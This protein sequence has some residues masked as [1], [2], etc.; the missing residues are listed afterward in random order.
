[1]DDIVA[2]QMHLCQLYDDFHV[3]DLTLRRRTLLEFSSPQAQAGAAGAGT[4]TGV[5]TAVAVGWEKW[6]PNK[7]HILEHLEHDSPMCRGSLIG[8][9]CATVLLRHI[10]IRDYNWFRV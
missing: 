1:V 6:G 7:A 4:G 2:V 3:F 9:R 10:L 5:G 8:E